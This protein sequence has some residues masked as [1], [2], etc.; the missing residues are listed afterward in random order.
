LGI[1]IGGALDWFSPVGAWPVPT[2]LNLKSRETDRVR[3]I[4]NPGSEEAFPERLSLKSLRTWKSL[5]LRAKV[6]PYSPAPAGVQTKMA[7]PII[8]KT[9][10][11]LFS[12]VDKFFI[13]NDKRTKKL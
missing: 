8:P 7:T 10:N 5:S 3:G 4:I 13:M 1:G 11:A 12:V 9:K 6:V 2:E